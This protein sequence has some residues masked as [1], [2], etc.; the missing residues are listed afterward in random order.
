MAKKGFIK[1]QN[2]IEILP[3]TRGELVLDSSGN[4]AF[5]STEFLATNSQPGLMSKED[6]AKLDKLNE[7]GDTIDLVSAT[8]DGLAPKI[9]TEA[10]STVTT[11]ADEWVLTSTKGATPT[12]RKLPTNAFLNYY[13]PILVN[14][15]SLLGN[16]NTALNI[17]AGT[18][19]NLTTDAGKVTINN[20]LTKLSQ[21]INDSGYLTSDSLNNYVRYSN[22]IDVT[23]RAQYRHVGYGYIA[24]G[25]KTAG[26]A[27]SFGADSKYQVHLQAD[28]IPNKNALYFRAVEDSVAQ[29]WKTIAFT[30][31]NG[32]YNLYGGEKIPNG[33]DLN[34]YK[35]VGT[36]NIQQNTDATTITNCPIT[37]AFI[38]K[39][40]QPTGTVA[41]IKQEVIGW[42]SYVTKT[43]LYV[44]STSSWSD[45]VTTSTNLDIYNATTADKLKTK[46]KLWGNDF[47]GSQNISGN[48]YMDNNSQ[49]HIKDTTGTSLNILTLNS[50]N[51]FALGYN[52]SA[53]GY[54]TDICGNSISFRTSTAN[55]NVVH[56]TAEGKVGIGTTN[57]GTPLHVNGS[58][59]LGTDSECNILMLR[60][61]HNYIWALKNGGDIVLGVNDAG[62][63]GPQNASLTVGATYLSPGTRDN[64]VDLGTSDYRWKSI[65]SY[66]GDFNGR[67]IIRTTLTDHSASTYNCLVLSV[68]NK[69][70]EVTLNNS[71][72]IGF[73]ISGY[74][75]G[76]LVFKDQFYFVNGDY[77]N[78]ENVYAKGFIKHTSSDSYVLLGGGGHKLVSD[79]VT[80]T[81]LGNYLPLTGGTISN[82]ATGGGIL[83]INATN[84]TA[85]AL[86]GLYRQETIMATMGADNVYGFWIQNNQEGSNQLLFKIGTS[87][88]YYGSYKVWHQGN[89]GEGSGLDADTLDG[90]HLNKIFSNEDWASVSGVTDANQTLFGAYYFGG[91]TQNMPNVYGQLIAFNGLSGE[92]GGMQLFSH[93]NKLHYRH[94]WNNTWGEW[95]QIAFID[96]N[97]TGNASSATK[98][99][100]KRKLWGQDFDGSADV[101]GNMT[102]VG[103][104]NNYFNFQ[105]GTSST[106]VLHAE[107][108]YTTIDYIHIYVSNLDKARTDRPLVLQHGYG[109]VGIGV[110]QPAQKLEV[111]GNVK[112]TSFLGNLDGT[113][114]NKLTGYVKATSASDL[115]TTDTLNTALGKLEYKAGIAYSWYRTITEDDTDEI[116]NKWDEVVDFVNNLA[117]D[118]SEEFVTR[119]TNQ[120]ITG[121]KTISNEFLF[122]S[123]NEGRIVLGNNHY[124]KGYQAPDM[125]I[126]I[127]TWY[128]IMES[129]YTS[130]ADASGELTIYS[131][132]E[133]DPNTI[134]L[135][136]G[137]CYHQ[138]PFINCIFNTAWSAYIKKARIVYK[139]PYGNQKA[140]LEVMFTKTYYPKLS[141]FF[142]GVGWNFITPIETSE[143]FTESLTSKIE[144]ECYPSIQV[145]TNAIR[146]TKFVTLGGT[147]SQF[148]KADGSLDSTT[149]ATT[150][151]LGSYIT[152][153]NSVINGSLKYTV[154]SSGGDATGWNYYNT[155][156][157]RL[158]GIGAYNESS[159]LQGIYLGWG[160]NPWLQSTSLFV[161][162]TN[163]LYKQQPVL[164]SGNYTD[165]VNSTNFPGLAGVRS[166]TVNGNYL[167]VNTN[168]TNADLTIPY[169]KTA[170][171][172]SVASYA[173]SSEINF[174]N[175]IW[176]ANEGDQD[177]ITGFSYAAVLN[178]GTDL[179]RGWQIWGNRNTH[180]LFWRPAKSDASA[181]ADVH[182]LLD[183]YNW[184][185]YITIPKV[186]D[187]YWANVKI[188]STSS[189]TTTPTFGEVNTAVIRATTDTLVLVSKSSNI[190]LRYNADDTKSLCLKASAFLPTDNSNEKLDLGGPSNRWNNF[191]SVNGDFKGKLLLGRVTR[192]FTN[193]PETSTYK[194]GLTNVGDIHFVGTAN[195]QGNSITWSYGSDTR[196]DSGIYVK[197]DGSYGSKMYFATTNLW[198]DGP[199]AAIEIDNKGIVSIFR[200]D[201]KVLS[202]NITA[203]K[204]ITA[205]SGFVKTNSS[206][207]YVLLG[208]GG[209]KAI[210]DFLL[211]SEIANQE[212]S[213]NLTTITKSLT[214]TADWMD[215]GIAYNSDIKTNGTYIVQV[216]VAAN[217][218]TG[219]MY[220]CYWSGIMSWYKDGTNDN[221]A[222]EIILHRSGHAYGNTLYLRTIMTANS[223]GRH[224]RL[225]IA[226]NKDLGAAYTYTF[227]FK[228]II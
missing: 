107:N 19:I 169:A 88:I 37:E 138:Y 179:Y 161:S 187:Y 204:T 43:R 111:N 1:D 12:W 166:V 172:L 99:Q 142:S 116:I 162:K 129:Y 64:T 29:D 203:N 63:T 133:G 75:W 175:V 196:A 20:S 108:I 205:G 71:P 141:M 134:K 150:T 5:H 145:Y 157:D 21:L 94:H 23:Q 139:A 35:T 207:S 14:G 110:A 95:K 121:Q 193:Y 39:V 136:F 202:G 42:S 228:R 227:K 67:V 220:N 84:T 15:T 65:N 76:S 24:N 209:H 80:E 87:D 184:S 173:K 217:D 154:T 18:N 191:Y 106:A 219:S 78:Y 114:V 81:S 226:A 8:T 100:T 36:Y 176:T 32:F 68:N 54:A 91:T 73:H 189:T 47:D 60:P 113:Y 120:T 102:D 214:V 57:P 127:D 40:S 56:I 105:K 118:I 112:A 208:G 25:W 174:S 46:V 59:T 137:L 49:I 223:D 156:G 93:S 58:I 34:N 218:G 159:V 50:N 16:D 178:V 181:W 22:R 135:Q 9:G 85:Y 122:T 2:N 28:T 186:T 199:K 152:K 158:A 96:S 55:K 4:Q 221:E 13:R 48:I 103:T 98:L 33:S 146:S 213:A 155:D 132:T 128:R 61:S 200:N 124:M 17:V 82:T 72:G 197:H 90:K 216:S 151:Q 31:Y 53:K 41:Y 77:S 168:G 86:I 144:I 170:R 167:R 51:L 163:L 123:G 131:R 198:D 79:F 30:D 140:Y 185:S 10:A 212:L 97:I 190:Y 104:I 183:N 117:V 206:D 149:Y 74:D 70:K 195:D 44:N 143:A 164:H 224:L 171:T 89:D 26:P 115:V 210:S 11:Q 177:Q 45:W 27:M 215:T 192:D 109:N 6:K 126:K 130:V 125:Q 83:R 153:T 160:A 182:T 180:S 66:N 3:I 165:Y 194:M 101:S 69:D 201:L 222:D 148:L 7:N 147:S 188:S 225:Q 119:K 62:V 52:S 211:K 38:L 92:Y